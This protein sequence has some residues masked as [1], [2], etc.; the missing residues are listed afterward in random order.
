MGFGRIWHFLRL[1]FHQH[2]KKH[3]QRIL[4]PPI[5][6]WQHTSYNH[7]WKQNLC[8]GSFSQPHICCNRSNLR[9]LWRTNRCLTGMFCKTYQTFETFGHRIAPL[10]KQCTMN[11]RHWRSNQPCNLYNCFHHTYSLS[12]KHMVYRLCWWT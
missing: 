2:R 4:Q 11:C 8:V 5:L 12:L 9:Y 1:I 6:Y 3:I 10:D 7:H